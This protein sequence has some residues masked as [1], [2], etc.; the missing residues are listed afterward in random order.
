MSKI[1]QLG[2]LAIRIAIQITIQLTNSSMQ[3][4]L[5]TI[6]RHEAHPC[7]ADP[8][9]PSVRA[10]LERQKKSGR[11]RFPFG[12]FEIRNHNGHV[13]GLKRFDFAEIITPH[14]P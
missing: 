1:S 14:K 10:F 5:Y 11:L 7:I 4:F 3:G 13:K 2:F 8:P 12:F 6:H 9:L